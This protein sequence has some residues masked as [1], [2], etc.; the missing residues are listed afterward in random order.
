MIAFSGFCGVC[1]TSGTFTYPPPPKVDIEVD[2]AKV[3]AGQELFN[4]IHDTG[5]S[6]KGCHAKGKKKR[7]KRRKLSRVINK[8]L[9]QVNKCYT[10]ADRIAAAGEL[11]AESTE[12]QNLR[13]FIAK[14]YRLLEYLKD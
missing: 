3:A 8:L 12:F 14:K 10:S 1:Y 6:C 13:I 9:P 7:F 4:K 2:E 11:D 5:N